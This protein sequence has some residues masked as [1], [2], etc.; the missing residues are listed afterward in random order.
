MTIAVRQIVGYTMKA[1][2]KALKKLLPNAVITDDKAE[3]EAYKDIVYSG[4]P[5]KT[6]L[7][8]KPSS[9]KE[10]SNLL[11]YCNDNKV[12]VVPW[13]GATNL[14]GSLSP[15]RDFIALDIKGLNKILDISKDDLTATVQAGATIEKL[16]NSL[17]KLCLTLGH[18][19][20]S[21]KSATVGGAVALDSAGNLYPKYGS[22]G[23]LVLS[24]KIAMADGSI[25]NVGKEASKSSSSP[26]LPSLFIGSSGIFGVILEVTFRVDH[27]PEHHAELGYAFSS[28]PKMFEAIRVLCKEGL[29]PHSYIGGTLPKVAVKL[30]PK[31]EQ[32]LVKMLGISAAL[33]VHYEGPKGIVQTCIKEA[34]T[35]LRKYGKKMP[36]KHAGEWW[37]NRHTYFE[38]NK[39]LADENIYLHVFD[40]CVPESRV[41]DTYK[42]MEK[43]ATRLKIKD[44]IS[45]S[46]FTAPDAYTVALY[47]KG[48]EESQAVLKE[49]EEEVIQVVHGY[50]GTLARTHGLGTLYNSKKI[51]EKEIGVEGLKLLIKMKLSLDPNNI[52]NPGIIIR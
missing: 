25:I 10:I 33:F 22:A 37:Q 47:L 7:V 13:G 30:Q 27:I 18:D 38:M 8:V 6:R 9:Y 17:N 46:L 45:H 52:L 20:W 19:P 5:P 14:S 39:Q 21:L 50:G 44:R 43:A 12:A 28:F 26:H 24:M 41:L 1:H 29:E 15:D 2:K 40:L 42:K 51:L 32:A 48:R 16:E 23:E 3:L 34:N 4:S 36:A 31:T 35:I 49:F 11:K